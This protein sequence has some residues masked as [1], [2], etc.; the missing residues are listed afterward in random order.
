MYNREK[1]NTSTTIYPKC[2]NTESER[3][4]ATNLLSS[5]FYLFYS[6]LSLSLSRFLLERSLIHTNWQAGSSLL[7]EATCMLTMARNDR[8]RVHQAELRKKNEEEEEKRK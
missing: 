3:M 8:R 2:H 6:S 1:N 4:P 7:P 5:S